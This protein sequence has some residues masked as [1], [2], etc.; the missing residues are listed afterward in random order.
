MLRKQASLVPQIVAGKSE[1]S[2][3]RI[4][5][6]L[7]DTISWWAEQYFRFEVTT[8]QSSRKV[9]QR[10][11]QLFLDYLIEEESSDKRVAW[12]PRL[13]KSFQDYLRKEKV[14]G[15]RRWNDRTV[16]RVM[17]HLKT[18]AKWIHK[19]RPFPLGNPMEKISLVSVGN[20]LEIERALTPSERRK[21]LDA[22]DLL[23]QVGG[24]SKDRSRYRN[25][26][27]PTHIEL[28]S[29]AQPGDDLCA[30]RDGDAAGGHHKSRSLKRELEGAEAERRGEGR[31]DTR[32]C[33]F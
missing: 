23:L 20:N 15:Q 29:V 3:I 13:S 18:F 27:R 4:E 22:A 32:V 5:E 6:S 26:E 14:D 10:D 17:A 8:S 7:P 21:L 24:R 25:A 12:T 31:Q 11:L 2:L 28:S 30:D 9:Q 19:L 33:D 16:N 1:T